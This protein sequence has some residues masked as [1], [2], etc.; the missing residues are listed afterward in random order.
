[1]KPY[2][3]WEFCKYINCYHFLRNPDIESRIKTGCDMNCATLVK[4]HSYLSENNQILEPGS[5]LARLVEALLERKSTLQEYPG[6]NELAL[7]ASCFIKP[8]YDA[9]YK[10]KD[11]DRQ[12][13]EILSRLEG[14]Q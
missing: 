13:D 2:E 11:L 4:F 12:I 8:I 1:M 5:D 14:A 10:V 3:P 6:C 7:D 9:H